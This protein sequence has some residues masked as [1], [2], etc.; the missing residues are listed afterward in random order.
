[1]IGA[2]RVVVGGVVA[3]PRHPAARLSDERS[4]LVEP[5]ERRP[6]G[7]LATRSRLEL[8]EVADER[9]RGELLRARCVL[10][11]GALEK[12]AGSMIWV[13]PGVTIP[14]A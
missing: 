7:R 10:R 8:L 14:A 5:W 1:M 4:I 6:V 12:P 11:W 9:A 3:Q 13:G 2:H